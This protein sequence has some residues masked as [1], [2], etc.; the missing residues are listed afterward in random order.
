MQAR[1]HPINPG[2]TMAACLVF[3]IETIPDATGLR[4]LGGYDP[5]ATD[6]QVVEQA[7]AKRRE[8]HGNDFLPL[9][10]HRVVAIACVFADERRFAVRALGTAADDESKLLSDFYRTVDHYVPQLVSWNGGGFDLPVLHYR[11]MIHSVVAPKYWDQGED[12][13][14]FKFNNYLSRYHARHTDL[15][16]LLALYQGRASV[17]LDELAKLCGFPGKLDMDGAQVWDNWRAGKLDDIRNYCETDVVNTYLL[18]C[19]FQLMRGAMT[20]QRYD[21]EML[22]VRET[23]AALPGAHWQAFLTAWR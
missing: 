14:D 20:G 13:R 18:W 12:D 7:L 22:R 17:R 6:E 8:T 3:D 5:E 21:A 4:R 1:P 9:H 2:H 10:L 11:S 16:D 19:R 23:L 15:M